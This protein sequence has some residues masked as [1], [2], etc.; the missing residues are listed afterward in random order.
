[1]KEIVF[2][3]KK[4]FGLS[5]KS[6]CGFVNRARKTRS[7]KFRFC[8]HSSLTNPVHEMFIVHK[9]KHK[10]PIHK[11]INKAE[12]LL[13][14]QGKVKFIIY[15]N[16]GEVKRTIRLGSI[17]SRHPFYYKIPPSTYH[18]LIVESKKVVFL[19]VIQGPFQ[20]NKTIFAKWANQAA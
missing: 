11:H 14:L 10:I 6:L 19:E 1:M 16:K 5:R 20:R 2:A 17:N 13:I 12:S 8:A 9:K 4:P 3:G 18:N 15:S 7:K